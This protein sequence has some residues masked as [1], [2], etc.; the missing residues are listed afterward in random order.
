MTTNTPV[1]VYLN[2]K[3]ASYNVNGTDNNSD[4]IFYFRSPIIPPIGYATRIKVTSFVFPL[5]YTLINSN[6]NRLVINGTTYT[7]TQGNYN[8]NT[9][10]SHILSLIPNTFTITFNSITNKYTFTNTSNFT[11]NS[12]STC[13]VL[14]GFTQ[15][16]HTS[17]SNTL[18]SNAVVNLS[19]DANVIY[20]DLANVPTLNISSTNSQRT[21]VLK[22]IPVSV[23]SGSVMYWENSTD[24]YVLT[25]ADNISF[26]H[27][28]ILGEDLLT[29]VQFNSQHWNMTL[30]CTFVAKENPTDITDKDFGEAY[31]KY[32]TKF[33][34]QW[35][36]DSE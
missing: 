17:V 7:L 8:A 36:K 29:P 32:I 11:I 27:I 30:E 10:R 20:I 35:V 19:G 18:S 12:T 9:L 14:L 24:S 15:Q 31:N 23:S 21:S 34:P 3:Y 28:R 2:S 5:S 1:E 16:S 4:M 26:F 25:Q 13:L 22:S 6:N 33:N